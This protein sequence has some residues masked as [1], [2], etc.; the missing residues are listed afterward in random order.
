MR[1]SWKYDGDYSEFREGRD[2]RNLMR[3]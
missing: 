1:V 3:S 2:W